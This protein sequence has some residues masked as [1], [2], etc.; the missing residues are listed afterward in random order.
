MFLVIAA[1]FIFLWILL[2][3][4]PKG[5]EDEEGFHY[6]NPDEKIYEEEFQKRRK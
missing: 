3:T 1:V 6:G 2:Y 4:T 5:Y